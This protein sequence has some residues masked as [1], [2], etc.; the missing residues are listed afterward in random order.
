M[1]KYKGD[2]LLIEVSKIGYLSLVTKLVENGAT[3]NRHAG[4]DDLDTS[5]KFAICY[6]HLSVVKYLVEKGAT[7]NSQVNDGTLD[8]VLE[9]GHFSV[10]RYLIEV[11]GDTKLHK[12]IIITGGPEQL[13]KLKDIV[14]GEELS[15]ENI[16]I[17]LV[18]LYYAR[19]FG[20]ITDYLEKRILK[21]R[22]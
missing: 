1:R 17:I 12:E 19:I 9:D 11:Q 21:L 13:S 4:S 16:S 7:V 5:L 6:G 22:D 18:H 8:G 3:V 2:D 15:I 20:D 10:V 14:E